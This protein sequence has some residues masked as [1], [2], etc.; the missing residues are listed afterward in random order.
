MAIATNVH[1][2]VRESDADTIRAR[3][4]G[5]VI[6]LDIGSDVIV[7]CG[8]TTDGTARIA[9]A[10]RRAAEEVLGLNIERERDWLPQPGAGAEYGME[11]ERG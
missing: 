3:R 4:T 10:F 8:H 7:F 6:T 1:V 11:A 2:H 9:A 5:S